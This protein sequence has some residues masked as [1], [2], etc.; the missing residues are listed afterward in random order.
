LSWN[1]KMKSKTAM[2]MQII[3]NHYKSL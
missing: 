2:G 3:I 1:V